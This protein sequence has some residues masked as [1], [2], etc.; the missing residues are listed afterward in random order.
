MKIVGQ[1]DLLLVGPCCRAASD[2]QQ[3]I[4]AVEQTQTPQR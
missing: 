4:P 3:V 2:D 1:F